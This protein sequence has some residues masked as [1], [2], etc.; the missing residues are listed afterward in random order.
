MRRLASLPLAL[1]LVLILATHVMAA[2]WS[3]PVKVLSRPDTHALPTGL[4]AP[5]GSTAVVVYETCNNSGTCYSVEVRRTTDGGASWEPAVV[6]SNDGYF[7]SMAGRG[8]NAD[9]VWVNNDNT[10][11]YARSTNGGQSY[12][13]AKKIA[14]AEHLGETSIARGPSGLVAIGWVQNSWTGKVNVRVSTD[15]GSSF[16][17]TH[18]VVTGIYEPG[19]RVAAGNG[20]VYVAYVKNQTLLVRRSTDAGASWSTPHK[21]SEQIVGA[22]QEQFSVTADRSDVYVAYV[23]ESGSL[24]YRHS[25]D[26]GVT[27]SAELQLLK[28]DRYASTPRLALEG[29]VLRA[30]FR[31]SNGL[32]YRE[33]QDGVTWSQRELVSETGYGAFVGFAERP[34]VVYAAAAGISQVELRSRYRIR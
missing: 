16:G 30:V 9:V 33:S 3:L 27:W 13:R 1:G 32:F 6:L 24:R 29:G 17:P 20:V 18:T 2:G 14:F 34:L 8:A 21:L 25:V 23:H 22:S 15:G 26:K 28:A 5:A 19:I 31:A 12:A 4:V 7:S 10:V 11:R